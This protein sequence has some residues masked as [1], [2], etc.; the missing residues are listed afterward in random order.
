[1]RKNFPYIWEVYLIVLKNNK[2]LLLRR[3]NTWYYDGQYSLP[4]GH[5]E[6]HET[7]TEAIIRET[8]EEIGINTLPSQLWSPLTV[9][10]M[11]ADGIDNERFEIF[12]PLIQRDGEIKNNEPHKCDDLA[13]YDINN[14]PENTIP[15]IRESIKAYIS[16]KSFIEIIE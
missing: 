4:A 5:M 14:L 12:F 16:G 6:G 11:C 13:R 9:F 1:M 3:A 15:Y 7:P 2:I 10:R 8:G